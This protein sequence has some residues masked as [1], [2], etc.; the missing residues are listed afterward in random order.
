MVTLSI[1]VHVLYSD[2]EPFR[3]KTKGEGTETSSRQRISFSKVPSFQV[4]LGMFG[5]VVRP[6]LVLKGVCL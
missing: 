6:K 4:S 1:H 3:M 5:S 2:M